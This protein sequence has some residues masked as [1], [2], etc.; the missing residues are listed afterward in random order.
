MRNFSFGLS[1]TALLGIAAA[2]SGN[3]GTGLSFDQFQAG[4]E[5]TDNT[6]VANGG[7]ENVTAGVPNSWTQQGSFQTAAP[8]G[9]NTHNSGAFAAQGPLGVA[10]PVAPAF[11]GY[12]QSVN[13]AAGNYF[14]SAYLWCFGENFDLAVAEVQ[15][16]GGGFVANVSLTN[17]D[18]FSAPVDGTRGAF[19][20]APL[21]V[22]AGTYNVLVKFDLDETVA[23]ARPGVAGQI[24][25]VAIT[26]ELMFSAPRVPEPASLSLV[27]AGLVGLMRRRR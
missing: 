7:F 6:I 18:P 5:V 13:L 11:N 15:D 17:S 25:N 22:T 27:A 12:S 1:A 10:D 19:F 8:V 14:L 23:G 2:A 24:D 16:S 20:F 9:A 21:S 4:S 26:P 3:A